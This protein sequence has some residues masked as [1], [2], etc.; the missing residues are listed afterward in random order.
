MQQIEIQLKAMFAK[1]H[2]FLCTAAVAGAII[3]AAMP[4]AAQ[5][6]P[7]TLMVG[8]GKTSGSGSEDMS[9]FGRGFG[10]LLVTDLLDLLNDDQRFANCDMKI[11]E[12][13]RRA[14]LVAEYKLQHSRFAD[15]AAVTMHVMPPEPKVLIEGTMT[16]A[17][18][19][20]RWSMTMRERATGKVLGTSKGSVPMDQIF[21]SSTLAARDLLEAA[22]PRGWNISGGGAR[23]EVSGHVAKIDAPFNASGVFPGGTA[24]FV[25][26]PTSELGGTVS[27]TLAGGGF[28]GSGEGSY[29]V[30]TGA[31]GTYVINQT[32]SGCVNGIPNSCKT[33]SEVLTLTPDAN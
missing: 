32:T 28:S 21:E 24:V 14:D 31:D 25:Y 17:D 13:R 19:S 30:A 10:D 29:S 18:G 12:W 16:D 3:L 33:N 7:N 20:V 27:Y 8:I 5:D 11:M 4:L 6:N 22:C 26:T 1:V 9:H 15:P 2:G 23:I